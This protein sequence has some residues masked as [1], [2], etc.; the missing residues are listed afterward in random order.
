MLRYKHYEIP[1]IESWLTEGNME[2]KI[3]KKVPKIKVTLAHSTCNVERCV[4]LLENKQ[5]LSRFPYFHTCS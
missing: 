5:T 1:E 2:I 3:N 4:T